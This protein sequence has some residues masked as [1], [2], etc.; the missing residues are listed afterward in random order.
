MLDKSIIYPTDHSLD[1]TLLDV[2]R[3]WLVKNSCGCPIITATQ[4]PDDWGT[5]N[6]VVGELPRS[7]ISIDIQLL[8]AAKRVK[9]KWLMIAEHDCLYSEEHVRFIP[10]DNE[11][12]YY[13]DNN[14]LL[15]Y[16]NPLHPEW[17]GMFS[18]RPRRRVQSQL[19]AD[20]KRYVEAMEFKTR[21]VLNP[22][23]KATY[24]TGRIAEPGC[25]DYDRT[26]RI[27][28]N[29]AVRR[30]RP[31]ILE[32]M[33]RFRCVDFKTKDP[34]IDIRHGGNFTGQ[35]RGMNRTFTLPPWGTMQDILNA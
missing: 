19:V 7:G 12:F 30:L 13:N 28:R 18:Y 3:K 21:I 4:K 15:Q 10:P 5:E 17:D 2:C 31:I 20:T 26:L 34:N 35:R 24:P 27:S 14:W 1:P 29:R 8:A 6:V 22:R 25:C 33:E 32:Y 9:T 23:W 11:N 16:R